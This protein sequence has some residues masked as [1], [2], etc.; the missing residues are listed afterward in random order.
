MVNTQKNS[1]VVFEMF[2]SHIACS[3]S[4][5]S[6]WYF[7]CILWFLWF[8]GACVCV[9]ISC[10]VFLEVV[11][12]LAWFVGLFSCCLS[13]SYQREKALRWR[14]LGGYGSMWRRGSMV[15]I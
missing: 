9:C 4:L 14:G 5:F 2:L 11:C 12:L 8:C 6:D 1:V 15:R 13:V 3:D 10:E 7:D